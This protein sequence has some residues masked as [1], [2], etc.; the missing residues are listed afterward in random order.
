MTDAASYTHSRDF[1]LSRP[2]VS[3]RSTP[4]SRTTR[5][6]MCPAPSLRHCIRSRCA[7]D[8]RLLL[9]YTRTKNPCVRVWRATR[10]SFLL[11]PFAYDTTTDR[12]TDRSDGQYRSFPLLSFACTIRLF[13]KKGPIH[14]RPSPS[15]RRYL[16]FLAKDRILNPANVSHL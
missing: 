10:P 2:F 8:G 16:K 6:Y 9:Y 5:V 3:D 14:R 13:A 1:F 4:L 15:H 12:P 7:C 11:I